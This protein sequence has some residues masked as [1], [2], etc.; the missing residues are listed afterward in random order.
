MWLDSDLAPGP[1][2]GGHH[3]TGRKDLS[4]LWLPTELKR[5]PQS[6]DLAA[7]PWPQWG[8]M[9]IPV[10]GTAQRGWLN[11]VACLTQGV[12]VGASISL[13]TQGL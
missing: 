8:H 11:Y 13:Q 3:C 9:P 6:Q 1:A 7:Y 12:S 10:A 5:L 4:S 2:L